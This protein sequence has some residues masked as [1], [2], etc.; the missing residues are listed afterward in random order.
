M[1][2]ITQSERARQHPI[3]A[4]PGFF[5]AEPPARCATCREIVPESKVLRC[6]HPHC[7]CDEYCACCTFLCET[8]RHR[9]CAMHRDM[10]C[11]CADDL[12]A[13]RARIEEL[14]AAE[15]A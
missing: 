8:G 11:S 2:S 3:S 9:S 6:N 7:R 13:E 14:E 10:V 5:D 12:A 15:A 1:E 4:P